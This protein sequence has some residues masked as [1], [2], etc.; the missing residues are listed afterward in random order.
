MLAPHA[1][2][3]PGPAGRTGSFT[4]SCYAD[5]DSPEA[6]SHNWQTGLWLYAAKCLPH[7]RIGTGRVGPAGVQCNR[8]QQHTSPPRATACSMKGFS[9]S[10][11]SLSYAAMPPALPALPPALPPLATASFKEPLLAPFETAY[12][13]PEPAEPAAAGLPAKDACTQYMA[14]VGAS[15]GMP[16]ISQ[17]SWKLQRC[18]CPPQRPKASL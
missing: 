6:P 1:C 9:C 5:H 14:G 7:M 11:K 3:P 2:L 4:F 8:Q 12:P 10:C 15:T 13:A 17:R 16:W 18:L